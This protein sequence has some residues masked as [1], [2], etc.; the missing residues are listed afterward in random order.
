MQ[1]D[2]VFLQPVRNF[3]QLHPPLDS[4][5]INILLISLIAVMAKWYLS[6]TEFASDTHLWSVSGAIVAL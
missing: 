4:F 3:K 2:A 6:T 1:I 5:S